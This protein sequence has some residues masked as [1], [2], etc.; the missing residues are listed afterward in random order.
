[1]GAIRYQ[2]VR[3]VER[4]LSDVQAALD[5]TREVSPQ[6]AAVFV[7][8]LDKVLPRAGKAIET[9]PESYGTPLFDNLTV[10]DLK[11]MLAETLGEEGTIDDSSAIVAAAPEP[12]REQDRREYYL[13]YEREHPERKKTRE[14]GRHRR[15]KSLEGVRARIRARKAREAA[16]I[17]PTRAEDD[18]ERRALARR[19]KRED[20][21]TLSARFGRRRRGK[22]RGIDMRGQDKP[23]APKRLA[24]DNRTT[25][26]RGSSCGGVCGW[27]SGIH[28]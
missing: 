17:M 8:L 14:E 22:D 4:G 12:Y 3:L 11:R 7:K 9:W 6:Q 23:P 18:A 13:K 26:D 10:A 21:R 27:I 2:I 28:R 1:M 25:P 16:E 20:G 19:V 24:Q 5:G 15:Q